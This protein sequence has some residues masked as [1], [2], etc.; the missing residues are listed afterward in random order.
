MIRILAVDDEPIAVNYLADM[1]LEWGGTEYEIMKAYNGV[2]ALERARRVRIDILLTDIRMPEMDGLELAERLR[3][4]WPKLKII[5]LTGHNDFG[6][7]QTAIRQGGIDYVLKTEGDSPIERAIEKACAE[8]EKERMESDVMLEAKAQLQQALPTLQKDYLLRFLRG[9]GESAEGRASRFQQLSLHFNPNGP[10][11]MALGKVDEWGAYT[12]FSDKTLML[13]AMGNIAAET[14]AARAF[15]MCMPD[16][17]LRLVWLIQPRTGQEDEASFA[18][19]IRGTMETIQETCRTLLRLQV[20]LVLGGE[21]CSWERLDLQF[22]SLLLLLNSGTAFPGRMELLA[23]ER[24]GESGN[25][26]GS[27]VYFAEVELRNRIRKLDTL[28]AELDQ[29][30]ARSFGILYDELTLVGEPLLHSPKRKYVMLEMFSHLTAFFMSYLNRRDMLDTVGAR[31]EADK[32]FR[33][34]NHTSLQEMTAYFRRLGLEAICCNEQKRQ[35]QSDDMIRKVN[36]YIQEYLHEDLS[37]HRL[38]EV[39]Y[40]SPYYLSRLYKQKTGKNLADVITEARIARAK[41]LLTSTDLKV[42]EIAMKVGIDSAPYFTRMFKKAVHCT[43]LE[44]RTKS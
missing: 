32:Y 30:D 15:I 39:V 44:Y 33:F 37:L 34:E 13:Y 42:A 22:D 16:E 11:Y 41:H 4:I 3:A 14:F 2:E 1:L 28:E 21:A 35:D 19:Y 18:A 31:A 40:L 43:P 20:S 6:Y 8:L 27:G 26:L 9:E 12:S 7:V 24:L 10:V 25:H 38:A 17:R 5:F 29:G 36:K 23:G